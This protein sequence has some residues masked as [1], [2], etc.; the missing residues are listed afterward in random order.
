[1]RFSFLH[2]LVAYFIAGLGLFALTLGDAL[3]PASTVA[4]AFAFVASWFAE[5]EL[6]RRPAYAP[7]WTLGLVLILITQVVRGIG[8]APVIELIVEYAALL[9]VSRLFSRRGARAYREIGAL[10]LLHLTVATILSSDIAYGVVFLGFVIATPWIFALSH[11]R[12]EVEAAEARRPSHDDDRTARILAS[13]SL[14]TPRYLA[15]TA[16]LSGPLF[17]L[18]AAM[19]LFFPRVGFGFLSF[20]GAPAQRVSGFGSNVELGDFGLIRSDPTVVLRI[21]PRDLG[22]DPPA[23]RTFRMRGTSFDHYDGH[24]WTRSDDPRGVGIGHDGRAYYAVPHRFPDPAR[25]VPFDVIVDPLDEPVIFLPESTVGLEIPPRLVAGIDV[26]R[27]I[28]VAPG[29]DIRYADGDGLPFRYTA[30]TSPNPERTAP[31]TA[32]RRRQYLQLPGGH[33]R[34][35]ELAAEWTRGAVTDADEVRMLATRLRDSGQYSYTLQMPRLEGRLPLEVFLLEARAGHCEYFSSALAIMARSLGIPARNVTGFY[36]GRFNEFGRYY[37][38]RQGDAH[39][40]VEVYLSEGGG[41]YLVDPTPASRGQYAPELGLLGRIGEMVDAIQTRWGRDIVGFDLSH[42]RELVRSL[43]DLF[44]GSA[45][46]GFAPRGP[47]ARASSSGDSWRKTTVAVVLLFILLGA[48]WLLW[49]RRASKPETVSPSPSAQRAI[50]LYERLDRALGASGHPRAPA[51]APHE[52]IDS[53]RAAGFRE[54]ALA[55]E[56]T[57]LYLRARFGAAD[58]DAD[59][60][61]RLSGQLSRLRNRSDLFEGP[62]KRLP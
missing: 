58:V 2:K 9:Q 34:I 17:F 23:S 5:G 13:T 39:S 11:L 18:T 40:W 16:L 27:E 54:L 57:E 45:S 33:E 26:G 6:I 3:G 59:L 52:R 25:D 49:R 35:A 60:V 53:L 50:A 31:L 8:G 51:T 14:V 37:A 29:I 15:G 48:G 24:R 10:A 32:E 28:R 44:G 61:E 22:A 55:E 21:A 56:V 7:G 43:R 19:F 47:S 1:M 20:G 4:L 30:W 42:Q 46:G 38:I 12:S 62:Q 36:G 41:W